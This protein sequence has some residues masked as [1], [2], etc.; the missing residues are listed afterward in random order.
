VGILIS[1]IQLLAD[2]FFLRPRLFCLLSTTMG[3]LFSLRNCA[4]G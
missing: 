2:V 1:E 4:N 3:T